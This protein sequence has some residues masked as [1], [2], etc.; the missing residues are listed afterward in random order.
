MLLMDI[1]SHILPGIDDGARSPEESVELLEQMKQQGITHVIA[2]PHFYAMY[3][4][5]EEFEQQA[6]ASYAEL[7]SAMAGKDL[8]Q[9]GV[10]CEAFYFNGIGKSRGIR[11]L[12]LCRSNYL[13]LELPNC[14]IDQQI[15]KDVTAIREDL[16]ITPILAHIERYSE[17]HGFK[18]I[19]KLIENRTVYAQV[20]ADSV[21]SGYKKRLIKKL[22]ANDYVSFL[23]TDSHSSTGRPPKMDEAMKKIEKDFG[24]S[25]KRHFYHNSERLYDEIF[26]EPDFR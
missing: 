14:T 11:A 15:V 25:V 8:P 9:V 26:R 20:N 13:L 3:Q 6:A 4:G 17:E 2:T 19:L 22:I 10:G 24:V 18:E 12:T 7:K 1:H 21:I 23:G 16:G 5:I